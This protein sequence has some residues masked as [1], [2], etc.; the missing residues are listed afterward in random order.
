MAYVPTFRDDSPLAT[1]T[2]ASYDFYDE[3]LQEDDKVVDKDEGLVPMVISTPAQPQH[4][5]LCGAG[6]DSTVKSRKDQRD[7]GTTATASTADLP[8]PVLTPPVFEV[9]DTPVQGGASPRA[10]A[11]A[12]FVACELAELAIPASDSWGR[13]R[14]CEEARMTV[15]GVLSS[16]I[17]YPAL[18]SSSFL[19]TLEYLMRIVRRGGQGFLRIDNIG[20]MVCAAVVI[21]IKHCSDWNVRASHI[22]ARLNMP[23][24]ALIENEH[25]MLKALEFD[26]RVDKGVLECQARRVD[27]WMESQRKGL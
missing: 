15:W 8:W 2:F 1:P 18:E 27:I 4:D 3:H 21:A 24:A 10:L 23:T 12:W 5:H 17:D 9:D 16:L 25:L 14:Q 7:R 13:E 11:T 6:K 20:G 26:L 19:V 22:A